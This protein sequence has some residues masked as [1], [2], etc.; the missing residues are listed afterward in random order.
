MLPGAK[1]L[2]PLVEPV[3]TCVSL[4]LRAVIIAAPA[5]FLSCPPI[6]SSRFYICC[7]RALKTFFVFRRTSCYGRRTT[8]SVRKDKVCPPSLS[9]SSDKA[10]NQTGTHFHCYH[11]QKHMYVVICIFYLFHG[12][13]LLLHGRPN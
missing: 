13:C 9:K 10:C 8:C 2:L 12:Q 5:A 11:L 3:E 6:F 4:V 7:C 1:V